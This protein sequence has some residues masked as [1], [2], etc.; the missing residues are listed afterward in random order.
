[1]TRLFG[2]ACVGGLAVGFLPAVASATPP[3]PPAATDTTGFRVN[4]PATYDPFTDDAGTF[5]NDIE[6]V[7]SLGIA[8]GG[9]G[10]TATTLFSP[11]ATVPRD[12]MASFIARTIDAEVRLH[13]AGAAAITPLPAYSGTNRFTDV[14]STNPHVANINRLA[15]A[16][17]V[18]GTSSTTYAP[19]VIVTRGQVASFINR[20]Q[21]F[22]NGQSTVGAGITTGYVA[23]AGSNYFTDDNGNIHE[24]N[25]N[26]VASKGIYIGDGVDTASP[27][28]G[29]PR[30]QMAGL[31]DRDLAVAFNAGMINAAPTPTSSGTSTNARPELI[32]AAIAST[33]TAAQET[34]TNPQGTRVRFNF[35]EVVNVQTAAGNFVVYNSTGAPTASAAG[36]AAVEAGGTSVLVNF[37]AFNTAALA[38]TL[39]VAAVDSNAT[40]TV[41]AVIDTD[42]FINPEGDAAIGSAATTPVGTAG[43][44]TAPDITTVQNFRQGVA[45]GTTAVDFVF[46]EIAQTTDPAGGGFFLVLT[47]NTIAFCDAPPAGDTTA[48]GG[49]GPGGN[50]TTTIT[51][52]CQNPGVTVPLPNGVPLT[53]TNTARGVVQEDA[54]TDTAVPASTNA[55][56]VSNTPDANTAGP[57]LVSATLQPAAAAGSPD[58]VVYTFDQAVT[59][60][61]DGTDFGVYGAAGSPTTPGAVPTLVSGNQV[62][63]QFAPGPAVDLAL[64]AN[65]L[66][67]AVV[68]AANPAVD[69][70]DDEVGVTNAAATTIT[71]G[72]TG[73]PDLTGVALAGGT[74]GAFDPARAIYT[75]DEDIT[76]ATAA[77]L[78]LF[79]ASGTR[80]TCTAPIVVASGGAAGTNNTVTCSSFTGVSPD[81]A[82]AQTQIK[83]A[84]LGTVDAGAV[85]P[86]DGGPSNPIGA[87]ATTGGTGTRV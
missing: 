51:V 46:D 18:L 84:V 36:S 69:N 77:N 49:T 74:G 75:F 5:E 86:A 73:A 25:I 14:P 63:V 64:G 23:P 42:G 39:T 47:D 26:G 38:A 7:A 9:A 85:T 8:L 34:P 27:N 1:L 71:P 35:D 61:T 55:L 16:G 6:A 21:A 52:L 43:V 78:Y 45:L 58:F 44:T 54:V 80:L 37:P 12:Q 59:V 60:A 22:M 57:D 24:A 2:A 50:G 81:P 68:L 32:S 40:N 19:S 4:I 53:G 15:A 48:G 72:R 65:V 87:E 30:G 70:R 66:D 76:A 10:G 13:K 56:Q 41:G 17:I 11:G 28:A 67:G 20:A 79:L 3:D 29:L 62:R 31:L 83:S 33:T 82:V